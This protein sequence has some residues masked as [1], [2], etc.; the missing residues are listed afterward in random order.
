MDVQNLVVAT[1]HGERFD[2]RVITGFKFVPLVGKMG[3]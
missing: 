1:R 3:W 2:R